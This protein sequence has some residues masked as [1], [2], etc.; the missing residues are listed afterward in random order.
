MAF[1][2]EQCNKQIEIKNVERL[3]KK[4]GKIL[5]HTCINNNT[6]IR[7][8]GTI[9]NAQKALQEIRKAK[10]LEKYGVENP[11][12]IKEIREKTNK[13]IQKV[14]KQRM[15]TLKEN[16]IKKFGVEFTFQRPEVI[17][18]IKKSLIKKY[19]VDSPLKCRTILKK[20]EQTCQNRYGVTNIMKDN[21]IKNKVI[22]AGWHNKTENEKHQILSKR[23]KRYEFDNEKFDSTWEIKVWKYCK[24]NNIQIE[25][26]PTVILSNG[27]YHNID[28]KIKNKL[29]E[30][31][32][33]YFFKIQSSIKEKIQYYKENNVIIITDKELDNLNIISIDDLKQLQRL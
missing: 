12:Q 21:T 18:N 5:C 32:S 14:Q 20:A 30:V 26:G 1:I 25:K 23:R 27:K 9:K 13:S 3:L 16:N 29:C 10:M 19:G 33:S 22:F 17:N 6:F 2:C 24:E 28:F 7:K 8:Y 11:S 4:Y 31:K 15:S